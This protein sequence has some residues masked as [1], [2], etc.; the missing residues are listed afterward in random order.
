MPQNPYRQVNGP[1]G[2]I[3][4]PASMSDEQVEQAMQKLYP[5]AKQ[6]RP[7]VEQ[8]IR[9]VPRPTMPPEGGLWEGLKQEQTVSP[10]K[11]R[12]TLFVH[13]QSVPVTHVGR[14]N[15]LPLIGDWTGLTGPP[16]VVGGLEQF[17]EPNKAD[18][19]QGA[20]RM[21]GGAFQT[22]SP[23]MIAGGAVAPFAAAKAVGGAILGQYAG[24]YLTAL[25]G[26][27][28]E[29]RQLGGTVGGAVGAGAGGGWDLIKARR[30]QV[31]DFEK[32]R[33]RASEEFKVERGAT[34]KEAQ[35][36]REALISQ[37]AEQNVTRA[38]AEA[39][40]ALNIAKRTGQNAMQILQSG[41]ASVAGG[42]T[43]DE[44]LTLK[45]G[46]D[47]QPQV[48]EP[49]KTKTPEQVSQEIADAKT[50]P[51]TPIERVNTLVQKA[52]PEAAKPPSAIEQLNAI[53]AK[54]DTPER[55][56]AT[57][58]IIEDAYDKSKTPAKLTDATVP[59]QVFRR[60]GQLRSQGY[61]EPEQAFT[62]MKEFPD[63]AEDIAKAFG[64]KVG[65]E[66]APP[67][68]PKPEAKPVQAAQ[69]PKGPGEPVRPAEGPEVKAEPRLSEEKET[70]ARLGQRPPIAPKQVDWAERAKVMKERV[71][72]AMQDPKNKGVPKSEIQRRVAEQMRKE[73]GA[74]GGGGPED[75]RGRREEKIN[76]WIS[77]IR[78]SK[79]PESV[80]TQAYNMLKAYGLD[81]DEII[82]RVS[83]AE[84]FAKTPRE[85]RGQ[86]PKEGPFGPL[87]H[88]PLL[89]SPAE[90][91]REAR[92]RFGSEP[93]DIKSERDVYGNLKWYGERRTGPQGT[94]EMMD[95]VDEIRRRHEATKVPLDREFEA[96]NKELLENP[97]VA[98]QYARFEASRK[99]EAEIA[100]VKS[101]AVEELERMFNLKD[102][103]GFWR[104][105]PKKRVK[106]TPAA[107]SLG[108]LTNKLE[109]STRAMQPDDS[110]MRILE[111]L[112]K[113]VTEGWDKAQIALGRVAAQ[114]IA[115]KDA[116]MRETPM[117]DFR[118]SVG[119]FSGTLNRSAME[120]YRFTKAI[121]DKI[122]DP[123]RR[124]AITNWLQAGGDDAVLADRASRSKKASLRA[125]YEA[126]RTL[127]DDEKNLGLFIAQHFDNRLR[128]AIK[129]GVL[130]DGLENYVPQVW[131]ASDQNNVQS[132]FSS[133]T[134]SGMLK[135]DFNAAKKRVFDSYFEGEQA[136][137]IPM[138]KDI[139]FLV[140]SWDKA[141]NQAI[142]SRTFIKNLTS[143][144]AKDG[145][146][147]IAPS[148]AGR[149]VYENDIP[150]S[151][152]KPESYLIYPKA[153][154]DE[155]EN[156]KA[157][158]H[159]ALTKW[160]WATK[161]ADGKP[162][163]MKGD[164]R[165]H[166]DHAQR[167]DNII[168]RG[169]WAAAHPVQ[170][171]I[172]KGSA[173]F[174]QTLLAAS[175]FH[176]IQEGTHAIFHK[177]NP[178]GPPQ[179]DLTNPSVGKLLDHGLVIGNFD[180][181][182]AFEEGVGTGGL[183]GKIPGI[184]G[185]MQKYTDYLFQDYIPRL[186]TQMAKEAYDRNLK[187]F[188]NKLANGEIT[189]D[190][191]AELT[192]NQA[193]AAFGELNYMMM[194]RHPQT[195]AIMRFMFLAP[196]FLEARAR[197]VGQALRPYGREQYAALFRGAAGMYVTARILNKLLDD[198][199]HWEPDKAF[200]LVAGGYE[201]KMRSLPGDMLHLLTDYNS[202]ALHRLNPT[203]VKPAMELVMGKDDFGRRRTTG[204]QIFD[205]LRGV[206]PIITQGFLK[207]GDRDIFGEG[208][209][210]SL[211]ISRAK[212]RTKA[213]A[214]AHQFALDNMPGDRTSHHISEMVR[215][216]ES[217]KFDSNKVMDLIRAGKMNPDD[218]D[219]AIELAQMP[220][221]YRD[222]H[223]LPEEDKIKVF[224]AA[225]PKEKALINAYSSQEIDTSRLLPQ[226]R[227][228]YLK[229]LASQ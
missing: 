27:S 111:R 100:G 57:Q 33:L 55:K 209:R 26:G 45:F 138:N 166:P 35:L 34:S 146:P 211:G 180:P 163:F 102:E 110:R 56:A 214:L 107:S 142:A 6:H 188:S 99:G 68:A 28:P 199:Y 130:K 185:I 31:V 3:N 208:L 65:R 10:I 91:E 9:T 116:Y 79:S 136:G 131:K 152:E 167:L 162:I 115:I 217:N 173:F 220:E 118:S 191:I 205:T 71:E 127:T 159:P 24:D 134:R 189:S 78:D 70:G 49:I 4:F 74:F 30:A 227:Q 207:S 77:Q 150:M 135:P 171:A 25:A 172:L 85:E 225:T 175:P 98:E 165:V 222:F 51:M 75:I 114:S 149:Q 148:G 157:L 104:M 22:M 86:P 169:K 58:Q 143:G 164:L 39:N 108:E 181:V 161:D 1:Q 218:I 109:A 95:K 158:N 60:M 46:A 140:A 117:T 160:I 147:I 5:P 177:V 224:L 20:A 38:E 62:L 32:A 195:Q 183:V 192:A 198:D 141:F 112:D 21:I 156:Y 80:Y 219:M 105:L 137:R 120:L 124:E 96:A 54:I 90:A 82:R 12:E 113:T 41:A 125:G 203:L 44:Q 151:G 14:G 210:G 154:P 155:T 119:R 145:R 2:P 223:R 186:K 16:E 174:K 23:L 139:G 101:P 37:A 196:D 170:T 89:D 50:R 87:T 64:S 213:G 93:F 123:R 202:F 7:E 52:A 67:E 178:F 106:P 193:N 187:R 8:A 194:G 73:L 61:S 122:P 29:A 184:G 94:S 121:K 197:F 17:A 43:R 47:A 69:A 59:E 36:Q 128:D 228:Q 206:M 66:P 129:M 97:Q 216:I 83:G 201:Y 40:N 92:S 63:H 13:G 229:D 81:D 221:L 48:T 153:A 226:Q 126:A 168:N 176:Q 215:D 212:Y 84:G 42:H 53:K 132:Y 72:A 19:Y 204:E 200:S 144:L 190:Q 15:E 133:L 11:G 88:T 179:I 76:E 18:K 182:A 103:R